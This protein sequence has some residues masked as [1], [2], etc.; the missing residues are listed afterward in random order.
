MLW[1]ISTVS[2]PIDPEAAVNEFRYW[3][4]RGRFYS[5]THPTLPLSIAMLAL[6]ALLF[7]IVISMF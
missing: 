2:R 6:M 7:A 4:Q 5:A 1:R 3:R